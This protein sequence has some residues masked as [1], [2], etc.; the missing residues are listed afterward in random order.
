M[1]DPNLT[2][3]KIEELLG[4][5]RTLT[6]DARLGHYAAVMSLIRDLKEYIEDEDHDFFGDR[7]YA[8]EKLVSL[9]WHLGA[10]FGLDID[11]GHSADAHYIWAIGDLRNL[12]ESRISHE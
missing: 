7:S 1:N 12:H 10:M 8:K 3:G 9:R 11:N 4:A 2:L 5:S 6:P